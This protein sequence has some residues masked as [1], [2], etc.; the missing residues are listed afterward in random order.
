ANRDHTLD[1]PLGEIAQRLGPA[2]LLAEFRGPGAAEER[3]ADLDDAAHVA[4]AERPEL[5]INQALP[6]LQ[7]AV[8]RHALI[9]RT[10]GDGA[11]G[12]IHAGGVATTGKDRNV[13]HVSEIMTVC[14][15]RV[16]IRRQPYRRAGD[17]FVWRPT[18]PG[19]LR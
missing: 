4:R 7:H 6:T 2:A 11:D 15:S 8:H 12:R 10:A 1:A 19:R 16:Q 9:E 17:R 18:L 3:A 14:R 13:L 5:S